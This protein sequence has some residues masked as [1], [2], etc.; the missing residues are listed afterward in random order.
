M[1]QFLLVVRSDRFRRRYRVLVSA[2]IVA[3]RH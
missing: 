2:R 3:E 1:D